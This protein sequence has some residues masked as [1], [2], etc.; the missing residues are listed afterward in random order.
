MD[1]ILNIIVL[2]LLI[3][4]IILITIYILNLK[5]VE[6]PP[7]QVIYKPVSENLLDIQFSK[8][9]RPSDIHFDMFNKSS[10]WIGGFTIGN[11]AYVSDKK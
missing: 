3:F 10:P 2:V 6:C 4:G 7:Q 9:N 5:S 1:I 11:K 8:E